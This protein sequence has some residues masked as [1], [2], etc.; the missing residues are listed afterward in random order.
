MAQLLSH[1]DGISE[2]PTGGVQPLG[3]RGAVLAGVTGWV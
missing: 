3:H 2:H 1:V